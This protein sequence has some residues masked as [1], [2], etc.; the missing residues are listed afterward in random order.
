VLGLDGRSVCRSTQARRLDRAVR[1]ELAVTISFPLGQPAPTFAPA[2]QG[3]CW[4]TIA[5]LC[6]VHLGGLA[7]LIWLVSHPSVHTIVAAA[8]AYVLSGFA[9]TAGYH[10]LFAHRTYRASAPVRWFFLASGA[11]TFQNS[12][13]AWSADHRAHHADTDGPGDPHAITRGAWFAHVSWLFRRRQASADVTRLH[14]LWGYRSIRLQHRWYAPIAIC[15]GLAIPALVG[16]VWHDPIG[17]LLVIGFLRATLML[18]ATFCVN[19]LAHLFGPRTF[20]PESSARN[21]R[22]TALITFGEGYHSY[23]H[24]FPYDFRNGVRW[25]QYDPGKWLI[26]ALHKIGL[27]SR[28]RRASAQLATPRRA[29]GASASNTS[30]VIP[31][32]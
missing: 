2:R 32:G 19:S 10:R 14:D 17:G 11:S 24:R 30:P 12:A 27:T 22:L 9:I 21:S 16:S 1:Q 20:D 26:V 18:Q 15:T 23:H 28:L 25:W 13:L 31:G 5:G 8:L 6:V 3:L 4:P 29:A 7:G